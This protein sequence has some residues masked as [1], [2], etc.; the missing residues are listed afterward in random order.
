[1]K[2]K[3]RTYEGHMCYDPRHELQLRTKRAEN[4]NDTYV[5]IPIDLATA[6]VE[7]RVCRATTTITGD[8]DGSMTPLEIHCN[9]PEGHDPLTKHYN[10]YCSW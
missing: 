9:L 5:V 3:P 10:G 2:W 6:C 4:G 1:M 7:L 8:E